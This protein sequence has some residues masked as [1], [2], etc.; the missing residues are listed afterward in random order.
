[1]KLAYAPLIT[2]CK[3]SH[4]FYGHHIEVHTLATLGDILNNR[5]ATGKI[6]KWVIEL[7]KYDIIY[8]PQ[9]AIKA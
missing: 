3:L 5:E 6:T 1:M 4:Y 7:S 2:S 8:K 9:I